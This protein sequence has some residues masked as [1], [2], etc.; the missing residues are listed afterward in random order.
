M[1]KRITGHAMLT[2]AA[3]LA[4]AVPATP[5]R[6]QETLPDAQFA[7]LARQ[8]RTDDSVRITLTGGEVVKGH[9]AGLTPRQLTVLVDGQP[10]AVD[11]TRVERVQRTRMGVTLGAII[12]AG[13]GIVAGAALASLLENEGGEYPVRA[14]VALAGIGA[15]A[16]MGI[17][18]L[19][20]LP[21][22][23]YTSA[24][25]ANVTLA[26]IVGPGVKGGVVRISF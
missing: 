10:R 20:N 12:G 9:L 5:A 13:T 18:A 4:A 3:V 1:D 23:V 7:R 21:R 2:L 16:G 19:L 8:V 24:P 6:A 15:G 26:P 17:D 14:A 11:T 25:A 22:T